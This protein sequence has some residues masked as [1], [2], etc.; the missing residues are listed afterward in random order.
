MVSGELHARERREGRR[1]AGVCAAP[2]TTG[3]A[4]GDPRKYRDFWHFVAMLCNLW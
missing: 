2:V 1:R 4:F 3:F